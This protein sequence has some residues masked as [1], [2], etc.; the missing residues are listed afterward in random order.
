MNE[1]LYKATLR[2]IIEPIFELNKKEL[3][4]LREFAEEQHQLA[5]QNPSVEMAIYKT[6][7]RIANLKYFVDCIL[8]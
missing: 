8:V 2:G 1:R 3:D 5:K 7:N 4:E 6:L